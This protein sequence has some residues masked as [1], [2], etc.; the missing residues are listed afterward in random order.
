MLYAEQY[1]LQGGFRARALRVSWHIL[2]LTLCF[3]RA[4]DV[5]FLFPPFPFS[6]PTSAPTATCLRASL[7][8]S[9]LLPLCYFFSITETT[10][11]VFACRVYVRVCF[12]ARKGAYLRGARGDSLGIVA[13]GRGLV[14]A[15]EKREKEGERESA[16]GHERARM[17]ERRGGRGER[18]R[19]R[20]RSRARIDRS[21]PRDFHDP[22]PWPPGHRP[23]IVS[24]KRT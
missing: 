2:I 14:C 23:K 20:P 24:A 9:P 8:L 7:P 16:P 10:Y 22:S 4:F 19:Q 5:V 13:G 18:A 12:L 1:V 15:T 11:C 6:T 21:R 17:S 3:L